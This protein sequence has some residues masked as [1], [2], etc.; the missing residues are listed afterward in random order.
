MIS[1]PAHSS[2]T[3]LKCN[4]RYL[5]LFP[6]VGTLDQWGPA[7]GLNHARYITTVLSSVFLITNV[8]CLASINEDILRRCWKTRGA[9]Y[10][11]TKE[12]I[13]R[14]ELGVLVRH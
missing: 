6:P 14:S 8:A 9:Q 11:I 12:E 4:V 2:S 5:A 1:L 10:P 13:P 7:P 3:V